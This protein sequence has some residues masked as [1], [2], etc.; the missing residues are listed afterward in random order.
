MLPKSRSTRHQGML[1]TKSTT[2]NT[3][4]QHGQ[5]E[6][7]DGV[8]NLNYGKPKSNNNGEMEKRLREEE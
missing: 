2:Q 1:N 8:E 7:N 6:V 3:K 4:P 5:L